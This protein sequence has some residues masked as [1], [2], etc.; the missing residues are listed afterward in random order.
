[1]ATSFSERMAAKNPHIDRARKF[2]AAALPIATSIL[3][4][5]ITITLMVNSGNIAVAVGI[6]MIG[7]LITCLLSWFAAM[8]SVRIMAE[9]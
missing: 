1:M 8:L 2:V 4:A 5:I 7:N 9:S 6:F 3:G